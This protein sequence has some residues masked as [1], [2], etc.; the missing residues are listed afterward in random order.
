VEIAD[1]ARDLGCFPWKSEQGG[2]P[3][4]DD[5]TLAPLPEL[6]GPV[7]TV[8][9][10][11]QGARR[12]GQAERT[13]LDTDLEEDGG[14]ELCAGVGNADFEE[15]LTV[16]DLVVDDAAHLCPVQGPGQ[17]GTVRRGARL[18]HVDAV[19]YLDR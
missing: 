10:V 11:R 13:A 17:Q 12:E 19:A 8:G 1:Q 18:G 6:L 16:R 14:H 5:G 9:G 2:G 4:R 7:E 3:G 15:V